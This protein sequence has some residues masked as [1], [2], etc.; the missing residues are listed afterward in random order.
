MKL[1]PSER[2]PWWTNL[3]F[4]N[5][6]KSLF[7]TISLF[8]SDI[9]NAMAR[10]VMRDGIEPR[11]I[12]SKPLELTSRQENS[13][14]PEILKKL[15]QPYTGEKYSDA[16]DVCLASNI[17]EVGVDIDRLSLMTVVS[18]PKSTAQYIQVTGRVGRNPKDRPGLVAVLYAYGSPRDL[19][20]FEHFR[21]YHERMYAQVEPTSVTPFAIPV[22]KRGLR[23]AIT[24]YLRMHMPEDSGPNAVETN[25]LNDVKDLFTERI[26]KIAGIS[27]EE[28]EALNNELEQII[29]EITRWSKTSWENQ[30]NRSDGLII[31]QG[32]D[33]GIPPLTWAIPM[34]MRNVDVGVAFQ[35]SSKYLE[36]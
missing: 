36:I 35:M 13:K 18:Q 1:E 8:Q 12:W 24:A 9:T 3:W 25:L 6:L 20:H 34:S 16:V 19:S 5:N 17:I 11:P 33:Q 10:L 26:K 22:I 28:F 30:D 27:S 2:D 4:F 29:A 7:N 31:T 23:G 32:R 21:S 15:Q 14:I